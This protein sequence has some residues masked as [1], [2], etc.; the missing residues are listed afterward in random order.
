MVDNKVICWEWLE[1]SHFSGSTLD[2]HFYSGAKFDPFNF[3]S[4]RVF[5]WLLFVLFLK[6]LNVLPP[7]DC[8][9]LITVGLGLFQLGPYL[10]SQLFPITPRFQCVVKGYEYLFEMCPRHCS[11][12]LSFSW[13]H[14]RY[15]QAHTEMI[16]PWISGH[17]GNSTPMIPSTSH[18]MEEG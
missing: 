18:P 8:C 6:N 9:R 7:C 14:V 15:T 16:V 4:P 12:L 1:R 3:I 11:S 10:S 13:V 17:Y 5:S 2:F